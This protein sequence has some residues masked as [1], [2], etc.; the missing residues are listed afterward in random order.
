MR[1]AMPASAA[2]CGRYLPLRGP[3]DLPTDMR[4]KH[5]LYR[6]LREATAP[7]RQ[8][9]REA[10]ASVS[11]Q[12]MPWAACSPC[13]LHRLP[14]GAASG[15]RGM[16]R[17]AECLRPRV[18][19][20]VVHLHDQHDAP[21][22][23]LANAAVRRRRL[24]VGAVERA[25]ARRVVPKREML[26]PTTRPITGPSGATPG[27]GWAMSCPVGT[28]PRSDGAPRMLARAATSRADF[29]PRRVRSLVP[30]RGSPADRLP[31]AS[32]RR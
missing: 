21:G 26:K 14:H 16:L 8:E 17:R 10:G 15:S 23:R 24:R 12:R 19:R 11:S 3:R 20:G 2:R 5:A 4:R 28:A 30:S 22:E 7:V 25:G 13:V 6:G 29:T 18:S 31:T 27:H 1:P 32:P 9:R